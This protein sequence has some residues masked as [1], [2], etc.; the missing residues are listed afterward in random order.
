MQDSVSEVTKPLLG[1][2]INKPI[3]T[4]YNILDKARTLNLL[5]DPLLATATEEILQDKSKGRHTIQLEIKR[6]EK[7]IENLLQKY[8]SSRLSKDDIRLCLYSI[9]DNNSF[10]NSNRKPITD[11]IELLKEHFHPNRL[12]EGYSLGINEGE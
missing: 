10:L 4:V 8:A 11:C 3:N 5:E 2:E 6:K 1:V 7:A 12:E 9:S